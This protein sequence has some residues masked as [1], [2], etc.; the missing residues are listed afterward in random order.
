[1]EQV[2]ILQLAHNDINSKLDKLTIF[3]MAQLA[4]TTTPTQSKW[5]AAGAKEVL[6][7]K[8]DDHS[9]PAMRQVP[10]SLV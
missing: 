1:M 6:A 9:Q 10:S 2:S 3:V 4:Q 8:H 7:M 5:K